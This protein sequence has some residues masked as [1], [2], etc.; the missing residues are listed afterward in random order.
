M[1]PSGNPQVFFRSNAFQMH[2]FQKIFSPNQPDSAIILCYSLAM[3]PATTARAGLFFGKNFSNIN[4]V[5]SD[6]TAVPAVP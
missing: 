2:W 1:V 4:K 5:K 6:W 3:V